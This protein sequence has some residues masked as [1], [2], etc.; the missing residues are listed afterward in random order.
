[1]RQA[2]TLRRATGT[3]VGALVAVGLTFVFSSVT[4]SKLSQAAAYAV[5]AVG[6]S[7]LTGWSGQISLGT[8]GLMAIGGFTTAIWL[9]SM[10]GT[11]FVVM[12]L[13]SGFVAMLGGFV[14]GLPATKLRGPYLAGLTLAF[15]YALPQI[16]VSLGAWAGGSGGLSVMMPRA[17]HWFV[18]L[19]GTDA[20]SANQQYVAILGI[21]VAAFCFFIVANLFASRSGRAFRLIRDND[22]AAEL[23]GLNLNRVRTSAFVIAAAFAGVGGSLFVYANGSASPNYFPFSLSITLLTLLVLGGLGT[24]E[25]A[26][27]A[28]VL[29]MYTGNLVQDLSNWFGIDPYSNFGLNF[30]GILFGVLLIATMLGTPNGIA[31]ALRTLLLKLRTR[32]SL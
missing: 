8:S 20:F 3:L 2:S 31:G 22:V 18:S 30:Q 13:L 12:L 23:T 21:A 24:I 16:P 19:V 6:L 1:M 7:L 9:R 17:P 29:M 15:A 4:N 26:L 14:L 27:I 32:R 11:P 10:P 28:G 25:G 5:A